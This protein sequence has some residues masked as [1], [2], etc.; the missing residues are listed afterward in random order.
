MVSDSTERE[1]EQYLGQV[2]SWMAALAEPVA[3]HSWD[4]VRD[5]EFEETDLLRREKE[6]IGLGAAAAMGCPYCTHFHTEGAKME[7]VTED[8]LAE[9]VNIA[10][11]VQYFSTILHGAEVD[12]D[13]FVD[14]TAAIVEHIETQ[15]AAAGDD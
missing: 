13:G 4:V 15:Q 12:Y 14:E 3:D 8:E 5:L 9:A 2:P 1:I 6:L 7:G 11:T 10:A